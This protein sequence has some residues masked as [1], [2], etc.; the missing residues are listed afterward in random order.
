MTFHWRGVD[1]ELARRW[2]L[3]I[4]RVA[5]ESDAFRMLP[6]TQ[7]LNVIPRDLS[8]KGDAVLALLE[9]GRR[10]HLVYLGDE[11]TDEDEPNF[12]VEDPSTVRRA[13]SRK[14]AAAPR[15][16]GPKGP[17][18][19]SRPRS[20]RPRRTKS[21]GRLVRSVTARAVGSWRTLSRRLAEERA[22]IGA[23]QN[24][25]SRHIAR[26]KHDAQGARHR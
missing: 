11:E 17:S 14:K 22:R 6:G 25:A 1:P 20:A 21:G 10:T 15:T 18:K 4:R 13:I 12:N 2:G 23:A 19:T 24:R 3:E 7:C 9:A 5:A 8:D 26:E 16:R